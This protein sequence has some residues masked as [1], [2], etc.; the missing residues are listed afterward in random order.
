[1]DADP[2]TVTAAAAA[3]AQ[4]AAADHNRNLSLPVILQQGL[5]DHSYSCINS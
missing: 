2:A 5:D 1:V 4:Q 3:A